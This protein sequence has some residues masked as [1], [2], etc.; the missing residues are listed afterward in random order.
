[1]QSRRN[2]VSVELK[3]LKRGVISSKQPVVGRAGYALT[4]PAS[5][6]AK[7]SRRRTAVCSSDGQ[8]LHCPTG[9]DLEVQFAL[10]VAPHRGAPTYP[11]IPSTAGDYEYQTTRAGPELL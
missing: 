11:T 5:G 7:R 9:T 2:I 4:R 6:P 3:R 8:T 1:M 10:G